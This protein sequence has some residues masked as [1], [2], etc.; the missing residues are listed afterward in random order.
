MVSISAEVIGTTS[1]RSLTTFTTSAFCPTIGGRR[2]GAS[3]LGVDACG[4]RRLR[5][6][7][8]LVCELLMARDYAR[9]FSCVAGSPPEVPQIGLSHWASVPSAAWHLA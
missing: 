9:Q 7:E 1:G 3:N 8:F 2:A 5:V 6:L 4:L